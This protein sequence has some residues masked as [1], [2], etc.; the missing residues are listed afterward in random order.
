MLVKAKGDLQAV[1]ASRLR[2]GV[3]VWLSAGHRWMEDVADAGAFTGAALQ[4]ALA[5][6]QADSAAG[7]VVDVYPLDV[8][9]AD[10][11]TRP[12][13]VRERMKARGPSVRPDLGK[14]AVTP[15]ISRAPE[16]AA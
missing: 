8:A 7:L 3:A 15:A 10:G 5:V 14:Q 12:L 4:Q 11:R 6:A 1:S 9:V 2:D 16:R 13:H